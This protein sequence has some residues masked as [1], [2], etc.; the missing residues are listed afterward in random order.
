MQRPA[1]IGSRIRRHA[2]FFYHHGVDPAFLVG[3]YD[4]HHSLK[5]GTF[6]PLVSIYLADFHAFRFRYAFDLLL[7][8]GAV[9][10]SRPVPPWC[11]L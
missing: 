2:V 9:A 8:I 4:L 7:F 11:R 6:E 10:A 1:L 5:L 3:G